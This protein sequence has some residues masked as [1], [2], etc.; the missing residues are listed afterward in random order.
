MFGFTI[1]NSTWKHL[2]LQWSFVR[3]EQENSKLSYFIDYV[4]SPQPPFPPL[5]SL[6]KK[7]NKKNNR[8]KSQKRF[9]EWKRECIVESFL[10]SLAG[11]W[12]FHPYMCLFLYRN[13]FC[14]F[15]Y[16]CCSKQLTRFFSSV[17]AVGYVV[18]TFVYSICNNTRR[19][20]N[21]VGW[22][23]ASNTLR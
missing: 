17:I 4:S 9:S 2:N 18:I 20:Y 6:I 7:V 3:C 12:G 23:W 11:F 19:M 16:Q 8:N 21:I 22:A 5:I 13:L 15:I 10:S 14:N 1:Y